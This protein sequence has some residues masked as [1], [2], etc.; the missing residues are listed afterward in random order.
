MITAKASIEIHIVSSKTGTIEDSFT[1]TE[2]G[3]GFSRATAEEMV[4]ERILKKFA[5]RNLKAV[6]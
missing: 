5:E 6:S 1:I 4:I 2:T 3:A